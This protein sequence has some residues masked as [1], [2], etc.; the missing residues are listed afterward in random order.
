MVY[1]PRDIWQH[2][3]VNIVICKKRLELIAIGG[4]Y[5]SI[6]KLLDSVVQTSV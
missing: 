6:L 2:L 4:R 5:C 1:L 3:F